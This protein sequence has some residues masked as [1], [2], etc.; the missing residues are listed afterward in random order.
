MMEAQSPTLVRASWPPTVA[1]PLSRLRIDPGCSM[2]MIRLSGIGIHGADG[3]WVAGAGALVL[4]AMSGAK[5]CADAT[6]MGCSMTIREVGV[7]VAG[8]ESTA[9]S[10][11]KSTR[12]DVAAG[13]TRSK[14][15]PALVTPFSTLC[16]ANLRQ[17][18]AQQP[19]HPM[20]MP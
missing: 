2:Q 9:D 6:N 3:I 15:W 11:L 5:P 10:W 1:M 16:A 12:F 4:L 8:E 14:P 7:V 20:S 19:A 18:A 17:A 13:E